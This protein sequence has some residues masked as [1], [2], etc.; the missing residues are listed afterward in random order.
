MNIYIYYVYIYIYIHTH[1][2]TYD[3]PGRGLVMIKHLIKRNVVVPPMII[4]FGPSF[5]CEK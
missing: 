2:Y 5:D 3:L 1:I 4:H